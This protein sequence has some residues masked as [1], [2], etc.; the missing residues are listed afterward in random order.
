MVRGP[1]LFLVM[2]SIKE[3]A[4]Q[5]GAIEG[6]QDDLI[7]VSSELG[8]FKVRATFKTEMGAREHL[9]KQINEL[10]LSL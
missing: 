9:K 7:M 2:Q 3:S 4:I 6:E 5:Q 10:L 1:R 8:S